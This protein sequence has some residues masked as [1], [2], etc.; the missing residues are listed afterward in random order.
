MA[1]DDI[2]IEILKSI[3]DEARETKSEF[4]QRFD[5]MD[6][7]FDAMDSHV[8]EPWTGGSTSSRNASS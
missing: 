6:Q 3:R 8:I 1:G 4:R 2:T 7:R 5:A